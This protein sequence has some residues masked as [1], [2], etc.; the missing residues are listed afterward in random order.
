MNSRRLPPNVFA[1]PFGLAGF[2]ATWQVAAN[3]H[4]VSRT[5][6][7]AIFILTGA[8]WGFLTVSYCARVVG[9][10]QSLVADLTDQVQAPFLSLVPVV[11]MMLA[12]I[13]LAPHALVAGRVL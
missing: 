9:R 13:G 5:V 7:E 4:L 11:G 1:I 3:D 6:A 10:S 2:G 8:V 12:A